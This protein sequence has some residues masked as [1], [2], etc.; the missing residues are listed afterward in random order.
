M[1]G[2]ATRSR[3]LS[4]LSILLG[5][6]AIGAPTRALA[7]VSLGGWIA[8]SPDDISGFT[9]LSGRQFRC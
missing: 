4:F 3:F 9:T 6:I 5:A 1:T 8:E 7:D 2:H